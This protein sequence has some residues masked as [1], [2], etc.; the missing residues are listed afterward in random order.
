MPM[1]VPLKFRFC[2][3]AISYMDVSLFKRICELPL[4]SSAY[5]FTMAQRPLEA[6]S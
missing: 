3:G 1:P 4:L 5:R 6:S 2:N